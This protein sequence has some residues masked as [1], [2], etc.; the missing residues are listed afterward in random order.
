MG[1]VWLEEEGDREIDSELRA[2][3]VATAASSALVRQPD[4]AGSTCLAVF[5]LPSLP[6]NGRGSKSLL[7]TLEKLAI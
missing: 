3:S 7:K 1:S 2:L 5:G 6:Q 4:R